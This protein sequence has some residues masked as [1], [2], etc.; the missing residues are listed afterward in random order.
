V[1]ASTP[2]T[3]NAN[4]SLEKPKAGKPNDLAARVVVAVIAVPI[5]L[6]LAFF[7]PNW[8]LWL[9]VTAA[10]AIGLHEFLTMSLHR[11]LGPE[12]WWS[13]AMLAGTFSSGYWLGVGAETWMCVAA[14][15]IG[16]WIISLR[17]GERAAELGPRLGAI[18]AGWMYVGVL[19]GG[20]LALVS[21]DDRTSVAPFQA[22]WL[23]FP[24]AVIWAGDTGAYFAGR[25]FGK[26][27]LAPRISPAKTREGAVGGLVAS[28]I[29]ALC[30]YALLPLPPQMEVWHVVLIAL[31]GAVLGQLGDLCESLLKRAYGAKDSGTILYGHGGMLDR[32]DAL[33][34]AAP[35][36]AAMQWFLGL[37]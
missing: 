19:F 14:A 4:A 5:L 16:V 18:F 23:I 28:T 7:A 11:D 24:M 37:R 30:A 29:S 1:S 22:G 9:L 32:V 2:E 20:L 31:P 36:F 27:K 26:H 6:G 21:V 34:F 13:I 8:S 25:A 33:I 10:A 35:Y 3:P 15:V 17:H 12:G